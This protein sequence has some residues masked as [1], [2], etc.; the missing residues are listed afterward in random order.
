MEIGCQNINYFGSYNLVVRFVL[1]GMD[2]RESI[3]G[4]P[5]TDCVKNTLIQRFHKLAENENSNL[6]G[7]DDTA[8]DLERPQFSET[9]L[10]EPQTSHILVL[11][12]P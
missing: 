1:L 11:T 5:S 9:P 2:M 6:L 12:L 8:S 3:H 4:K 10:S 7:Y